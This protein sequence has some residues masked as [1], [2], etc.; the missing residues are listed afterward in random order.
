MADKEERVW[1][2]ELEEEE[3]VVPEEIGDLTRQT[4]FYLGPEWYSIDTEL[5]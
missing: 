5:V 2:V 4:I 1:E 3:E